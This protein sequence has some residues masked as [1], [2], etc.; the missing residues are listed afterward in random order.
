MLVNQKIE[1]MNN[2]DL[3]VVIITGA[4][5]NLGT[6]VT[7]QFL[8][9]G[10]QVVATVINDAAKNDLPSNVRLDVRVVNLAD[11]NETGDFIASVIEKYKKVHA[12]LML[13]GGFAM[14][15]IAA[16][17][18][19]DIE[20]QLSLNFATAYHVTRPLLAHMIA[21]NNGRL[22][23]IGSRPAIKAADGKN[24][25]AYALAKSLLFRLAEYINEEA[26]GKNITATVVAPSTLDTALNRKN[27]PDV[28][29][30]KWVKP[31][32]LAEVLE[33]VVSEKASPL[34]ETVLKVYNNA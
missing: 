26:K 18:F 21:N 8:D 11:E 10:Y 1:N 28:D 32:Q 33:F 4:N 13:V 19:A 34:R 12:A 29:P 31:Q 6:V 24:V 17:P 25:V 14:G 7:Q 27:M 16:T 5:G 22:V 2:N 23:F 15:N 20:K 30:E 9:S 3:S